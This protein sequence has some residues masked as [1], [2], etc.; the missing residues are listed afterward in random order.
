MMTTRRLIP[1]IIFFMLTGCTLRVSK[2]EVDQLEIKPSRSTQPA[3]VT[4]PSPPEGK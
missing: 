3:T 1:L 4:I 2:L